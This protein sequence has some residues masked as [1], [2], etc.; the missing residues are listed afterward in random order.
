[1]SK[2]SKNHNL[3]SNQHNNITKKNKRELKMKIEPCL[4]IQNFTK[5][6]TSF[7]NISKTNITLRES[8][9][10]NNLIKKLFELP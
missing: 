1:M 9:I 5:K 8:L 2:E 4:K 6:K 3:S 10:S 7:P